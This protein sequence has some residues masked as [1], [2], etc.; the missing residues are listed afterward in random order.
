M[1]IQP[2]E[3]GQLYR[4]CDETTLGFES[5]EELE[6]IDIPFGQQRAE[7]AIRFA[8]DMRHPGYNLYVAGPVGIGKLTMVRDLLRRY[9]FEDGAVFDWCYVNNFKHPRKPQVLKL[10]KGMG[11][12]LRRDMDTLLERLLV[13]LPATF[14]SEE[15][16]RRINEVQEE[17]QEREEEL[18]SNLSKRAKE[19]ELTLIRTPSGYTI[20]PIKDGKLISSTEFNRLPESTQ[21]QVKKN[22]EQINAQLKESVRTINSWQEEAFQRVKTRNQEF[23]QQAVEPAISVLKE[24]YRDYPSVLRHLEAVHSDIEQNAW[25]FFTDTN[26]KTVESAPKKS[27]LSH[28][29]KYQINVL[30]DNS[31]TATTP[32]LYLDHPTLQNLTGRIE[33]QSSMGT[34][35]T[36]FTLIQPGALHQANG[37][38][39]IIDALQLLS[40]GF[41]WGALKRVLQSAEIRLESIEQIL[42]LSSTTTLE[43]EPIPANLKVVLCGDR[44]LYH[45]LK[46]YDPAFGLL[47]KVQADLS[48]S[49]D[50]TAESCQLYARLLAGICLQSKLLP[51]TAGGVARIIEF[52]ARLVEDTDKLSLH[53]AQLIDLVHKAEHEARLE[54]SERIERRHVDAALERWLWH[55]NRYQQ[56]LQEQI[57]KGTL[58]IATSGKQVAQVN[59]LSVIQLGDFMFGRPSRITATARLGRGKVV[60]IERESELGGTLHSKAVMII[61]ALLASRYARQAPLALSASLV[62]EQS[63]GPIDGDSA[64]VAELLAL[65]SAITRIPLKQSI[66]VTGSLNQLGQVQPIGGVNEKIEG[67]FDICKARGLDGSHGVAIPAGNVRRLM[68]R[69]EVVDACEQGQ[70]AIYPLSTLND[71][72]ALFTGTVAGEPDPVGNYPEGSFNASVQEQ[73]LEFGSIQQRLN[74]PPGADKD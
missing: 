27:R 62:F 72:I 69:K 3:A 73:L 57:D 15:Y 2:L 21:Q 64:S 38:V 14:K 61:S 5:T 39:L 68:L 11:S 25:D 46:A 29:H 70:F 40:N 37:G 30:V 42:S 45:M 51:L 48:E 65:L 44:L 35:T 22:I 7:D 19:M 26:E 32:Q 41:S 20:A 58:M 24:S 9:P 8:I 60:D 54:H 53:R 34:L 59:G 49:V 1:E 63:Y 66:A 13:T 71:A 36:D 56:L 50:R 67:Y 31:D 12:K 6:A 43:P 10:E 23:V 52:S 4:R 18:F 16:H 74:Q 55:S 17:F 33:H 28:F 47:F